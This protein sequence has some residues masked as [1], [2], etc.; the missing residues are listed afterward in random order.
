MKT[1][2]LDYFQGMFEN[3]IITFNPGWDTDAQVLKDFDDVRVIQK[4]LKSKGIQLE[5]EA[6]EDSSWTSQFCCN[7]PR[8]KCH[9]D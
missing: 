4:E 1:L 7:G 6:A 8:W 2:L 3:N 5:T 9:S